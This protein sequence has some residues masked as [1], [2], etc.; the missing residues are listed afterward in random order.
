MDIGIIVPIR[1]SKWVANLVGWVW[2]KNE[3][4]WLCVEFHDSNQASLKD[5]HPLLNMDMLHSRW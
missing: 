4:I 2:K 1:Y 5:N 3:E